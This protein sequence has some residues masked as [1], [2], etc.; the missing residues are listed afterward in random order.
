MK[1]A[2]KSISLMDL[3]IRRR[4][5]FHYFPPDPDVLDE[6]KDFLDEVENIRLSRLLIGLNR[7]LIVVG[8]DRDR[9]LGHSFFL[10]SRQTAAPLLT[11]KNR[12]RYEIV[13]LVEEYCYAD[14]SLMVRVLGELVEANGAVNADVLE[15][16][17]RFLSVL[18]VLSDF[19]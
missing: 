2:D 15:D 3:A 18:Q 5:L 8:V 4:F 10:I 13:P 16:D 12:F 11:L 7:R 9:V 1:T 19:E 6:G 17:E 14:L